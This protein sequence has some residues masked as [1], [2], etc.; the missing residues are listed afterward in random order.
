M[1]N[2]YKVFK[3]LSMASA[4]MLV[5]NLTGTGKAAM[6]EESVRIDNIQIIDRT[7]NAVIHPDFIG[8]NKVIETGTQYMRISEAP[9]D[10]SVEG[11]LSLTKLVNYGPLLSARASVSPLIKGL[12]KAQGRTIPETETL[13]P[14]VLGEIMNEVVPESLSDKELQREANQKIDEIIEGKVLKYSKELKGDIVLTKQAI[15]SIPSGVITEYGNLITYYNAELNDKMIR[16]LVNEIR[17]TLWG[18]FSQPS[19]EKVGYKSPEHISE[20]K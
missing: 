15:D 20:W 12:A 17:E 8:G 10:L 5:L 19:W 3:Y 11:L 16:N 6:G 9:K 2:S 4:V 13:R 1:K 7:T 18:Y 14:Y